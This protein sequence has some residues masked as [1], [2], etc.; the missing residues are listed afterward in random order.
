[1]ELDAYKIWRGPCAPP[2]TYIRHLYVARTSELTGNEVFGRNECH[3]FVSIVP[4]FRTV[5]DE[6]VVFI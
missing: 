2:P 6:K 3:L 1:M 4:V 5:F